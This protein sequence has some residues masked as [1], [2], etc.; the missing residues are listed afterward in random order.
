VKIAFIGD[1]HLAN[2]RYQGGDVKAG[3][4]ARFRTTL[5]AVEDALV[6]AESR[7][8]TDVVILGD[9]FDSPKPLPQQLAALGA[10]LRSFAGAV[11]VIVGN[12]DRVSGEE[13]DHGLGPLALADDGEGI[14]VYERPTVIGDS[15]VRVLLCPFNDRS[16]KEW[17]PGILDEVWKEEARDTALGQEQRIVCGHFGLWDRQSAAQQPWLAN[18][19]DAIDVATVAAL[20]AKH[21]VKHLYVG[22]YH[23]HFQWVKDGVTLHQV[24]AL[25]PTGFDNPGFSYGRVEEWP[26]GGYTIIPGP[27]FVVVGSGS[28]LGSAANRADEEGCWIH[29]DWRVAPEAYVETVE[30]AAMLQEGEHPIDGGPILRGT[31]EVHVDRKYSKLRAAQAAGAA[32]SSETLIEAVHAFVEKHP[33]PPHVSRENVLEHVRRFLGC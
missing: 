33:M 11:H 2:H 18:A 9:V 17:L 26:S 32:R 5:R 10:V 23:T 8:C 13:G 1:V 30:A 14:H 27:R 4:N 3:M 28:E 20:L 21:D 29:A 24:G 7:G 31:V 12:H 6:W 22:N 25:Q 15:T 19:P 16:V